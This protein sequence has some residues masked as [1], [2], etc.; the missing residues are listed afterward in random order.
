MKLT[1]QLYARK[2]SILYGV[3]RGKVPA[4]LRPR[5][6][7]LKKVAGTPSCV[8]QMSSMF[9]CWKVNGHSDASCSKEIEAF[10][11][12]ANE[13]IENYHVAKKEKK[14]GWNQEKLDELIARY[15]VPRNKDE[16]KQFLPIK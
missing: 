10:L 9:D 5:A 4:V 3:K 2:Q 14:T 13:S 16:K 12:C 7:P 6:P 15:T 1:E 8:E 11:L